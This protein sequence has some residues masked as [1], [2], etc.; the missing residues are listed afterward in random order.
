MKLKLSGRIIEKTGNRTG[1]YMIEGDAGA[2]ERVLDGG[3]D[4]RGVAVS[5]D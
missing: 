5:G 1:G 4:A 2:R 3:S